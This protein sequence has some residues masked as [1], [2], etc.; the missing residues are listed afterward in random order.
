MLLTNR[1]Y[2]LI[3]AICCFSFAVKAQNNT[4]HSIAGFVCT[5]G[6]QVRVAEVVVTNKQTQVK[7]V[8]NDIGEFSIKAAIGDTLE[9][10]KDEYTTTRVT[11]TALT[12]I[13]VFMQPVIHLDQVSV[14]AQTKQQELN[15]VMKSYRSK[16]VYYDGKPSALSAVA[17]PLNGLYSLFGKDPKD[18][19]RF[20]AYSK[21]ELEA[22][23]D[24]RK[25]NKEL[26]KKITNLP[27]EEVQKF[28]DTFTPSHEDL[29]KM[30]DY[31]VIT[32]I[33]ESLESYKKYGARPLQ[34]LY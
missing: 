3:A 26:V 34:K 20:A 28:M 18:A 29:M 7:T 25:Y 24:H 12:D 2:L 15:S 27:D 32:Y 19:R 6:T 31:D 17:S 30:N 4:S 22:S 1:I 9:F 13:V 8:T 21:Q 16:G 11:I 14:K 5:K 10:G 33:K 23:Q